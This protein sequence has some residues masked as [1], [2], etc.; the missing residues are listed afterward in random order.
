MKQV[1]TPIIWLAVTYGCYAKRQA[2]ND[3]NGE[4]IQ[5]NG[6]ELSMKDI[7][8]KLVAKYLVDKNRETERSQMNKKDH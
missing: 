3:E 7:V 2:S 6:K 8:K 1:R 4:E 5:K